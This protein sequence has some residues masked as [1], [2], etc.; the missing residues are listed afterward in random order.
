MSIYRT[1]RS[2]DYIVAPEQKPGKGRYKRARP[3]NYTDD[4]ITQFQRMAEG[5]APRCADG[6]GT[7]VVWVKD[8]TL[9]PE[10]R[11]WCAD[12]AQSIKREAEL[13]MLARR[14]HQPAHRTP[15]EVER[16]VAAVLARL[17][18]ASLNQI[19]VITQIQ[20]RRIKNSEAWI[21]AQMGRKVSK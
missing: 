21:M 19:F 5:L 11:K 7:A 18:D 8:D 15:E 9:T 16:D 4:A 6:G 14:A 17:P 13:A 2:T 3:L 20:I 12:T 10:L 1:G